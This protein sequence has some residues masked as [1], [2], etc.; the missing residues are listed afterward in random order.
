[1]PK[2]KNTYIHSLSTHLARPT[3]PNLA[4][5]R[6]TSPLLTPPRPTS[7]LL[8]HPP[9]PFSPHLDPP[10]PISPLFVPHPPPRP[11][12]RPAWPNDAMQPQHERIMCRCNATPMRIMR[13]IACTTRIIINSLPMLDNHALFGIGNSCHHSIPLECPDRRVRE[14]FH[15]QITSAFGAGLRQLV[16]YGGSAPTTTSQIIRQQC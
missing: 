16:R 11:S 8:A 15:K 3:S 4:P 2:K 12:P 13:L 14:D 7:P 1:M 9:R 10:R 6:P 5:H